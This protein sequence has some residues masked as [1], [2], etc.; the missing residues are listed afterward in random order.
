MFLVMGFKGKEAA[1]VKEGF[2]DAFKWMFE[3]VSTIGLNKVQRYSYLSLRHL[4]RKMDVSLAALTMREWQ[5]ESPEI[6]AEM[7]L[8]EREIQPM[9][10]LFESEEINHAN[11]A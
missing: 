4:N 1:V 5:D 2:I 10:T 8:L 11:H 9:L 3:Q 6:L 7:A